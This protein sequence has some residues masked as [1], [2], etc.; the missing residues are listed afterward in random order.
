MAMSPQQRNENVVETQRPIG[1]VASFSDM[2]LGSEADMP[3]NAREYKVRK[4][5]LIG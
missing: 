1:R 4:S 5:S 3:L 2:S